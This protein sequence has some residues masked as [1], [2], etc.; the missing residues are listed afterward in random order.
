[1]IGGS[2]Q[3][4]LEDREAARPELSDILEATK[5]AEALTRQLLVFS[6]QQLLEPRVVDVNYVARQI[7]PILTRLIGEDV[8]KFA[9]V[10][11]LRDFVGRQLGEDRLLVWLGRGDDFEAGGGG[12]VFL[13]LEVADA[14]HGERE[15]G[16]RGEVFQ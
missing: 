5:R 15:E 1:M 3:L 11:D 16:E 9:L 6:R 13:F 12:D 10:I 7:V 2:A 14:A 8:V 4:L